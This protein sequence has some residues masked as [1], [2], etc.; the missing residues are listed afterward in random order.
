MIDQVYFLI[1]NICLTSKELRYLA[2]G[3]FEIKQN[4][5]KHFT[6]IVG[7]GLTEEKVQENP[8][9]VAD[10]DPVMM[11][12]ILSVIKIMTYHP[13]LLRKKTEKYVIFTLATTVIML[14]KD[15][16]TDVHKIILA[17]SIEIISNLSNDES[18]IKT[19]SGT[20]GNET[21]GTSGLVS[22]LI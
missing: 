20:E 19:I 21:L 17:K 18:M 14:A 2:F 4:Y 6:L 10:V 13:K 15:K 22:L 9:F 16:K 8:G 1:N 7:G 12:N 11:E 5:H 3:K